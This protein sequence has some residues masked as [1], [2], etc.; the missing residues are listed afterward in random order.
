[1]SYKVEVPKTIL[2]SNLGCGRMVFIWRITSGVLAIEDSD[3]TLQTPLYHYLGGANVLLLHVSRMFWSI[4]MYRP[5]NIFL[6]Y[7]Q[8]VSPGVLE[9]IYYI[10]ISA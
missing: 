9:W 1:M 8:K 2:I 6:G 7:T 3:F 10:S 4:H 5:S